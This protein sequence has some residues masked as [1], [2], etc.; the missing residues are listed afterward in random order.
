VRNVRKKATVLVTACVMIMIVIFFEL[1]VFRTIQPTTKD[2]YFTA[3]YDEFNKSPTLAYAYS[4]SPPVSMYRAL[5][6][7]LITGGWNATSLKNKTIFVM[8]EYSAFINSPSS[9][10]FDLLYPV[11]HSVADWSP[12]Q[13][14]YTTYR[15]AWRIIVEYSGPVKSIPPPGYYYVDAATAELVPTGPFD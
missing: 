11:T 13:V 8:L 4:F 9:T 5:L 1:F 7:V 10:G 15:Y 14:N 3:Y 6:I 2:P 12:K